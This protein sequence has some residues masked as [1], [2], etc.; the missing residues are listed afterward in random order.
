[1]HVPRTM[2]SLL[3]VLRCKRKLV[4]CARV[5]RFCVVAGC[6]TVAGPYGMPIAN[7]FLR[8]ETTYIQASELLVNAQHDP[9]LSADDSSLN[10][11]PLVPVPSLGICECFIV[12]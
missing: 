5:S 9:V 7:R 12:I 4:T 1:M 2:A 3:V 6:S 10:T 8:S 11:Q